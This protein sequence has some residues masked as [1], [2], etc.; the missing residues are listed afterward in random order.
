MQQSILNFTN[1]NTI[2]PDTLIP[3]AKKPLPFPLE[4]FDGEVADTYVMVDRLLIK[5]RA[6]KENPVNNTPARQRKLKSLVY[7]TKV[8]LKMLKEV[9]AQSSELWY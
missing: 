6:A 7:K 4:N 3:K 9:S 8:C 1:F 5:L 2:N